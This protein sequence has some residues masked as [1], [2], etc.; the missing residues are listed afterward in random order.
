VFSENAQGRTF[1]DV[2]NAPEQTLDAV[3]LFFDDPG[4]QRR[5]EGSEIHHDR[6]PLSGVVPDL[7]DLLNRHKAL[8]ESN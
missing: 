5:V 1:A 3:F 4:R 2:L 8:T 7:E 6:S